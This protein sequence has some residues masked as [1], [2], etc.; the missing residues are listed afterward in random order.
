MKAAEM[1]AMDPP[2]PLLITVT[3][4]TG[5]ATPLGVQSTSTIG[6]VKMMI[7]EK[8]GVPTARQRLVFDDTPQEDAATLGG[9]GV[10]DGATI[11]LIMVELES[12]PEPEPEPEP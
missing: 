2:R 7:E 8:D 9:I 10:G 1:D 5:Q 4:I 3:T 6:D 11:H 12:G